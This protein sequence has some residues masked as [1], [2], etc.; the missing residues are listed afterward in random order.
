MLIRS[1]MGVSGVST[2]GGAPARSGSTRPAQAGP[3]LSA[4]TGTE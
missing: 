2:W 1:R 4:A 3:A